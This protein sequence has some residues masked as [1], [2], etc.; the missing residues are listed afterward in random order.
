MI[1]SS[2]I[3]L[4]DGRNFIKGEYDISDTFNKY[5]I[6]IVEKR[7]RKKPNEL[8]TTLGS[9]NNS[10]FINRIIESYQNHPNVLKIKNK[11]GLDLNKYDF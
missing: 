2:D 1:G 11:F 3:T 9:L 10:D 6:T 5:Y 4:I 8:G 7:C